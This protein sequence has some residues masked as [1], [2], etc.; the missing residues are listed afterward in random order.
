MSILFNKNG[1]ELL[2]K[3]QG[4]RVF[5]RDPVDRGSILRETSRDLLFEWCR[6]NCEGHYWIGMGFGEFELQNDAT[7]FALRWK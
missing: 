1:N 7:L 2:L 5:V 3:S 4:I 6:E